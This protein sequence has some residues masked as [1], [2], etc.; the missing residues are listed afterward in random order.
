M[1]SLQ[2]LRCSQLSLFHICCSK[3]YYYEVLLVECIMLLNL[4]GQYYLR[5]KIRD[6]VYYHDGCGIPRAKTRHQLRKTIKLTH[7]ILESLQFKMHPDKI[8]IGCINK[9]FE[10]L[11]VHFCDSHEISNKNLENHHSELTR[12]YTQDASAACID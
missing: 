9:G 11:G 10:F 6:G 7:K 12:R 2:K 4:V 8:F 3:I 1:S 5:W